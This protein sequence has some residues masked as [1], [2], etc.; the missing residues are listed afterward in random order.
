MKFKA[1]IILF[2]ISLG[3]SIN[4]YADGFCEGPLGAENAIESAAGV[5]T[6][7]GNENAIG[8]CA[9]APDEYTVTIYEMGLCTS[10]PTAPT[11]SS[12]YALD[13]CS[14]V[15]NSA[16]GQTINLAAGSELTLTDV[17]RP[18][19]GTYTHAYMVLGN[20]FGITVTKQFT[21]TM[22][23]YDTA[24]SGNFCWT[25]SGTEHNSDWGGT[26][27]NPTTFANCGDEEDAAPATYTEI[28][29]HFDTDTYN[30]GPVSVESGNLTAYLVTD[31]NDRLVNAVK[32]ADR[33]FGK[34]TLGTAVEVTNTSSTF[35]VS[36][37][38]NQATSPQ[39]SNEGSLNTYDVIAFGS[40]P[41]S[42]FITVE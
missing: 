31:S 23:R 28:L 13:T 39:M 17:T 7:Q 35:V 15:I 12:A 29:D 11:T 24:T 6:Y 19:N 36:F 33:I 41:F 1:T 9:F 30:Y 20:S 4:S 2:L 21:N 10:D 26:P 25:T 18:T 27:A 38:V 32:T 3:F 22:H 8:D 14:T 37:G 42:A 16:S 34:Q 40:G 5:I